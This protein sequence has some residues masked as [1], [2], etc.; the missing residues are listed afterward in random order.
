[1]TTPA[2]YRE[3][4]LDCMR[5]AEGAEDAAMRDIMMGLARVWMRT[6]V[7]VEKYVT[8]AGDGPARSIELR[9]ILD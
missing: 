4:A 9:R 8:L 3:F 1:M 2:E 6:S 5:L 7:E